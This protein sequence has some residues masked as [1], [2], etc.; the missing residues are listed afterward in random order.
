MHRKSTAYERLRQVSCQPYSCSVISTSNFLSLQ[1]NGV[2][3]H[4]EH[5]AI[6]GVPFSPVCIIRYKTKTGAISFHPSCKTCQL[7]A[8]FKP[9]LLLHCLSIHFTSS[10]Q[11]C[12]GSR[13]TASI[14]TVF[15]ITK[16]RC[17]ALPSSAHQVQFS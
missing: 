8:V 7:L 5:S 17:A 2:S 1:P 3:S 10:P 6:S 11:L 14:H 9:V 15:R 12:L 16:C 13:S 4:P